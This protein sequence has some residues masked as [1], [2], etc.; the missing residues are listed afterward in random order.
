MHSSQNEQ[1]NRHYA[2]AAKVPML[3]PSTAQEA[4]EFTKLAYELS[5]RHDTPVMLRVTT[6]LCHSDGVVEVGEREGGG[7]ACTPEKRSDKYVM[8]PG[9][10]RARR[11]VIAERTRDLRAWG[12][13]AAVNRVER[14]TP[15]AGPVAND[16]TPADSI[17]IISSGIAY[18]YAK[19]VMPEASFLKLGLTWPLPAKL[20]RDFAASVDKVYVVEELDLYLTEQVRA[21]GV[22]VE[23]LPEELQLGEL[24]PKRIADALTPHPSPMPPQ[25]AAGRGEQERRRDNG[26]GG[27]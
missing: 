19:E 20:I 25:T 17:G 23:A 4:L 14:A 8:I 27:R 16:A 22:T 7:E 18:E 1:D 5:E 10:A 26:G 9:R 15:S 13:T 3:E 12:E 24:S 21:L 2:R 11:K 6:R